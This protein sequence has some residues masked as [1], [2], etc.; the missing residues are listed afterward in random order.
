MLGPLQKYI[1]INYTRFGNRNYCKLKLFIMMTKIA[2]PTNDKINISNDLLRSES[3]III[4]VACGKIT[5]EYFIENKTVKTGNN[6]E[7]IAPN[8][9][10]ELLHNCD[11]IIVSNL[12]ENVRN[13][14]AAG[15]K[16]IVLTS[17]KIITNI[18]NNFI[19]ELVRKES[20]T[21]CCP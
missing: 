4:E 12:I 7:K 16:E 9:I 14:F 18:A 20:N 19:C 15:N 11:I 13:Y 3:F 21:L 6:N 10:G 17:E 1:L 5:A 2:I 8:N